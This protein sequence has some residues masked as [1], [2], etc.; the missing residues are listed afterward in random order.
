M[1]L[2]IQLNIPRKDFAINVSLSVTSGQITSIFGPSGCGKT[3]VMRAIAGL[4]N[5]ATGHIQMA[6]E[7]WQK[8]DYF[9]PPHQRDIGYVF[10]DASLF[11][12]LNVYDNLQFGLRRQAKEKRRVS[13]EQA[14]ELLALSPLLKRSI[15]KLSGGEK[16]RVAIAR[17]VATSPSVLLFD[18]PLA[19][20]D[21]AHKQ[22]I[23]RYIQSL[24][25][26]LDIPMLYVS[27]AIEEVAR[28]S[29]NL[30]LLEK[31]Q[32]LASGKTV[33]L[34]SQLSLPLAHY[35]EAAAML[36]TYV[37]GRDEQYGL[38]LLAFADSH[39]QVSHGS[40]KQGD[41]VRLRIMARDVSLTLQRHESSSILNIF[42]AVIESMANEGPAQKLVRLNAGG[43]IILSRITAKSADQLALVPGMTVFAQV[44]AVSLMV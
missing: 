19:A 22:E 16:Q 30:V 17:A 4:E 38:N 14:I 6:D 5:K 9:R 37:T 31:G 21:I 32:Q 1:S 23:L 35:E 41:K 25:R 42:P 8:A 33:D 34:L 12:H 11:P 28:L 29:D 18:E 27:H 40:L 2:R 43:Q 13:L 44:K 36:D 3:S 7:V 20:V 26:E 24:H 15:D 10:Q 39:L